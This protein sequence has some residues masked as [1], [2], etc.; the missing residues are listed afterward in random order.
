M[1]WKRYQKPGAIGCFRPPRPGPG[2]AGQR[3]YTLVELVLVVI[4]VSALASV[5]L[6]TLAPG[7][8]IKLDLAATEMAAAMRFARVEALRLGVARGF[9]Q[10]ST[11]KRVRVFSMDTQ[12]TPATLVYDIY[13]PIDKQLYDKSF[14]QQPFA[15]GGDI[16]HTRT[17]FDT[18]TGTCN[19]PA[20]VFFDA[21]GIPWCADPDNVLLE[22]FDVTLTIGANSRVVTLHGLTGRVTIQ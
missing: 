14:A 16:N 7:Q 9:R 2:V 4:I 5:V 10:Q 20:N 21:G 22:R 15:F 18:G 13:H 6:P 3:G 8:S 12:T 1:D 11:A 19:T 17:Y